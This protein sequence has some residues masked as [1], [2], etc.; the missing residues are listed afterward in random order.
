MRRKSRLARDAEFLPE[1][2]VQGA[3][4]AEGILAHVAILTE[5]SR[6][7]TPNTFSLP[8]LDGVSA[9]RV[10]VLPGVWPSLLDFLC[11]QFP[12]VS[13]DTW[14]SRFARQRV[15]DANGQPLRPDS[16]CRSGERIHYYR[17][18]AQETVIPFRETILYRDDNIL[19]AD[20]PHFL[21]VIPSGK[22][23]QQSLLVRLRQATGI[24][25][26]SPLHRIDKDTAG[27]VMFSVNPVTR[28]VYHA[29]F[30]SRQ[31]TK[32]YHAIAPTLADG[33]W[34]LVHASR[35]VEDEKFFRTRTVPGEANS[36]THIDVISTAGDVSLY[37]L[38]PVTGRKH[39]LRVHLAS[40]GIPIVNDPLYPEVLAVAE[41]D[42]SQPLQ[43]LAQSLI[44]IDPV[45]GERR[46]FES[47]RALDAPV[48]SQASR[49]DPARN[50]HAF[51]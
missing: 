14:R 35:L 9:S 46:C 10:Q 27:L 2:R 38:Q 49:T 26:L 48:V 21:P 6:L 36:E 41:D 42:F 18:L 23:V 20:K 5:I 37:R 15:L 1:R 4:G 28:D 34:P 22:Y 30:R 24:A 12:A 3:D 17:E 29:L 31:V 39:Q 25:S 51:S 13:A 19:V 40:L 32:T 43:L 33:Q 45:T 7:D 8:V 11:A 50:P 44:F 47:R 16:P